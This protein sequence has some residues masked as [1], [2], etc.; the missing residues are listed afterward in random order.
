[1]FWDKIFHQ[2]DI[3]GIYPTELNEDTYYIIGR[4]LADYFKVDK[5]AV[6]HDCRL[7]S[8][9]LFTALTSGIIDQGVNVVNLG[10]ISTEINYFASGKYGFP[11]NVIISAS[12]NPPEYNGL[13]IVTKGA[14]PLHGDYGLPQIRQLAEKNQFPT[15]QTK[16]K[17]EIIDILD[18]WIYHTLK[19]IDPGKLKPLKVVIDAG[20]GMGGISW[21]RLMGKLPLQIIPMY[22]EP[23]GHFPHHPA[24]PLKSENVEDLKSEIIKQKA[25]LGFAID[26]DADRIFVL[27]ERGRQLSGTLTSAMLAEYLLAKNGQAPI[28]YNAVCGK[29]LPEIIKTHGGIPIRVKVGHSF[30]KER[31][32]AENALFAGEHSGHFYF[33]DNFYADSATIAGLIFLEYFSGQT[34]P[35]SAVVSTYDKYLSSGEINFRL[36]KPGGVKLSHSWGDIA[37]HLGKRFKDATSIDQIDGLSVWYADWWFNLRPSNTEP[38]VRLNLE[39]DTKELLDEKI[40]VVQNELTKLGAQPK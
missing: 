16:G 40:K 14:I 19:F 22:F 2:Y 32:R 8:P 29:I 6:G 26:G 7:S 18:D 28:L 37:S 25:D 1:M 33:R 4:A 17:M 38:L 12:H 3:R 9:S 30:I 34:K 23:D 11:A 31:M 13:K 24:D 20:N 36:Q 10:L 35:L 5:I 27:D 21:E 39:A 15:S